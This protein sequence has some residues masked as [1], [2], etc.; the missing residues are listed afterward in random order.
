VS[1][2]E[3]LVGSAASPML[4]VAGMTVPGIPGVI[5]GRSKDRTWTL[6]TGFTDN[7]DTY[8]EVLDPTRQQYRYNG[9]F[10]P[11]E[12]ISQTFR[13]LG[14]ADTTVRTFRTV[15]GPVVGLDAA[16]GQAFAQRYAFW[17]R[18]LEMVTAFYDAWKATSVGGFASVASR[19]TMSFNLFYA[20]REGNIA[21]WHVGVY[22]ERPGTVD[23]RLPALGDGSQEWVGFKAFAEHPQEVNPLQGY[24]VNWN[25]KPAAWWN[26]G[27][28]VAWRRDN[29]RYYDGARYL[30]ESLE[31]AGPVS[32]ED[33]KELFRVV[34]TNP[35]SQEYPGT[36]QQVL[37]FGP[38]A[39]RAENVIPP[40]QSG[41]INQ[42]G[43]PSPN[44]ADQWAL[45]I[46]SAGAGPI[47]MKPFLFIGDVTGP[48]AELM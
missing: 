9:E 11:F 17:N 28:N 6:T 10:R 41:F 14:R 7:V 46:S 38:V 47:L 1:E 34:R 21:Y 35:R 33:L 32:F 8:I 19:V 18:E 36:Y 22:P 3:L 15:H 44:F 43:Q 39:T 42:A 48:T 23:P 20:D 37:A 27:D 13:R 24:F 31:A 25:N 45:Y 30:A 12:V 16:R 5:I 29:G 4:H 26:Q 40:G 2:V